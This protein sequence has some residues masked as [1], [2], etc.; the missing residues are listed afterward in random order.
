MGEVEESASESE[1]A[2]EDRGGETPKE[3]AEASKVPLAVLGIGVALITLINWV[4]SGGVPTLVAVASA[5][6]EA[7]GFSIIPI[8]IVRWYHSS[9]SQN[10]YWGAV[11]ATCFMVFGRFLIL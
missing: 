8:V 5:F 9:P 11:L 1:S 10:L 3:T 4:S 6:G 7:V 2:E